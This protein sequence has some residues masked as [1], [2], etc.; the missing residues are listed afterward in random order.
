MSVKLVN[1]LWVDERVTA[2]AR[3]REELPEGDRVRVGCDVWVDKDD[4]TRVL[5]GTASGLRS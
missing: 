5:A 2:R 3:V 1:V 4:G